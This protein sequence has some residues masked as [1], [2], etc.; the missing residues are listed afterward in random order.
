ML[1]TNRLRLDSLKLS[2]YRKFET[3]EVEFDS[4]LTVLTGDNASGKSTL[5]D[6]ASVAL[7]TYLT[8]FDHS[9]GVGIVSSDA[10]C[11]YVRQGSTM[12]R[13]SI[14]PVRISAK[15]LVGGVSTTWTRALNGA[16]SRTTRNEAQTVL[17]ASEI[18]RQFVASGDG[19]FV[20]PVIAYYSTDRLWAQVPKKDL[21]KEDFSSSRTKGYE[22]A[23]HASANSA[24]IVSWFRKLSLWEWQNKTKSPE[25]NAV[26]KAVGKAFRS[27]SGCDNGYIDYDAEIEN[28]VV[29]YI[30]GCGGAHRDPLNSMSDGYRG[31]LNLVADVARRMA[32][33]NPALCDKV[34]EAPGVVMIDEV[35]LHLH[36]R[37]QA[38]IL[39][40]L[41][42]IFPNV[43]FIVTSH[44]PIVV[45]SVPRE[46]VRML[47]G[48]RAVV[49]SVETYGHDSNSIL[50]AILQASARPEGLVA[51]FETFYDDIDKGQYEAAGKILG[52]IEEKIGSDDPESIAAK[53][54]LELWG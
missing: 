14:Y 2:N 45:A 47:D 6:A 49:P 54:T 32:M 30:D 43:Q 1:L 20:L 9:K 28:I 4:R 34:L 52:Q 3:Y 27:A 53:T 50:A 19:S 26:K 51:L 40:D 42:N 37:W 33:L 10:R 16:T 22:Q 12:D 23:L 11:V 41:A 29:E 17:G 7:G 21:S 46:N 18:A 31:T 36:P 39:G 8:R 48:E 13:Q 35:D 25:Y 15:G 44:S 24:R 38:K 5:L